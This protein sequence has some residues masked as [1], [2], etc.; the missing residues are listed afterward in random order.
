ME[1]RKAKR[2]GAT[3]A[4]LLPT[5]T[6]A[7]SSLRKPAKAANTSCSERAEVQMEE[8]GQGPPVSMQSRSSQ[9][10]MAAVH[11]GSELNEV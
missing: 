8:G 3:P 4:P 1:V 10:L 9:I 5:G 11:I 7:T 2:K 6:G